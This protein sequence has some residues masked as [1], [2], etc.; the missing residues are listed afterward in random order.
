MQVDL[1]Q[2]LY[3][4]L[5]QM[6]RTGLLRSIMDAFSTSLDTTVEKIQDELSEVLNPEKIKVE[7]LPLLLEYLGIP[8]A[9]SRDFVVSETGKARLW[10]EILPRYWKMRGT[11]GG[12][13][14]LVEELVM[15]PAQVVSFW[16][17]VITLDPDDGWQPWLPGQDLENEDSQDLVQA[18]AAFDE[19]TYFENG[20]VERLRPAGRTM[21]LYQFA[22]V[23][24][25]RFG[26]ARW[27]H[28]GNYPLEVKRYDDSPPAPVQVPQRLCLSPGLAVDSNAVA[29]ADTV[30]LTKLT[31][32]VYMKM[33]VVVPDNDEVR[34]YLTEASDLSLKLSST[35][36]PIWYWMDGGTEYTQTIDGLPN[37]RPG[38][39]TEF[40]LLWL[41]GAGWYLTFDGAHASGPLGYMPT[42]SA[43]KIF[44]IGTSTANPPVELR[45]VMLSSW[46]GGLVGERYEPPGGA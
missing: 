27:S 44:S 24:D 43:F 2:M 4:S 19:L 15:S 22:F 38:Q 30:A 41:P 45:L 33:R 28:T 31:G 13:K 14:Q 10:A 37:L 29:L 25:F 42:M 17:R 34:I 35:D 8:Q 12:L 16:D 18:Y 32:N 9:Q 5:R 20:M 21:D 7:Y 23:D 6:D 3:Q 39:E 40:V 1:Y 36:I 46:D 11:V 26:A